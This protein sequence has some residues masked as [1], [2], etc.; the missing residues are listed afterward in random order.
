VRANPEAATTSLARS[1]LRFARASSYFIERNGS[2][3]TCHHQICQKESY[4][5]IYEEKLKKRIAVK[6]EEKKKRHG[7]INKRTAGAVPV[8]GSV[9]AWPAKD[10]CMRVR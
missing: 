8:R 4:D 3:F 6:R 7:S 5:I 1:S 2:L 9:Y 10:A